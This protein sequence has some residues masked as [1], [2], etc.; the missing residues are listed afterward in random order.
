MISLF[1]IFICEDRKKLLSCL[2]EAFFSFVQ[3]K[4]ESPTGAQFWK[5]SRQ[6]SIFGRTGD[7]RVAISSPGGTENTHN[8]RSELSFQKVAFWWPLIVKWSPK[9]KFWL[10]KRKTSYQWK[11]TLCYITWRAGRPNG[12]FEIPSFQ[13]MNETHTLVRLLTCRLLNIWHGKGKKRL[14][15]GSML[16]CW[17]RVTNHN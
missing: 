12:M 17:N 9:Q 2:Y 6:C 8:K 10:P 13:E 1:V 15:L 14:M 4:R 16:C 7:Q 5:F 3:T 11:D